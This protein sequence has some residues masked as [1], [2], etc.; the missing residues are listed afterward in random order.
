[1]AVHLED[2]GIE[3]TGTTQAAACVTLTVTVM[4]KELKQSVEAKVK[5]CVYERCITN[6]TNQCCLGSDITEQ[7]AQQSTCLLTEAQMDEAHKEGIDIICLIGNPAKTELVDKF[8]LVGRVLPTSKLLGKV[9]FDP[10]VLFQTLKAKLPRNGYESRRFGGSSGKARY[11]QS[12]FKFLSNA[13]ST[14]RQGIG[15]ILEPSKDGRNWF[16][17]Y[18]SAYSQ[19]FK[20]VKYSPPVLGGQLDPKRI[21]WSVKTTGFRDAYS[22]IKTLLPCILKAVNKE[23][24]FCLRCD[25]NRRRTELPSSNRRRRRL[26]SRR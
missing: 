1:M 9:D 17:I 14:C 23:A 18:K 13:G 11:D 20:K 4:C 10:S 15:T 2:S 7:E 16:F 5:L 3:A 26:N 24:G 12:L 19:T 25:R 21:N 6:C 22:S 8:L